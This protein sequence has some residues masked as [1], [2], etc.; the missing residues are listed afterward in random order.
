LD[1]DEIQA[2]IFKHQIESTKLIRGK[3]VDSWMVSRNNEDQ[4]DFEKLIGSWMNTV[5]YALNGVYVDDSEDSSTP[6]EEACQK[7]RKMVKLE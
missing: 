3:L 2:Y 5:F 4:K 1:E 6:Q 7:A